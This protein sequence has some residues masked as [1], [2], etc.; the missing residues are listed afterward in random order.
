M[1]FLASISS[2]L[3]FLLFSSL[4]DLFASFL[5]TNYEV[6]AQR[7]MG[8][9]IFIGF[10]VFLGVVEPL[11]VEPVDVEPLDVGPEPGGAS[12]GFFA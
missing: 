5:Y 1:S 4:A 2:S 11:D 8:I 7:I 9:K 6:P 12:L 3:L 10:M